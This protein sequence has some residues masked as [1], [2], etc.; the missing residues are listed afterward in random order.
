MKSIVRLTES[1]LVRIIK[2]IIKEGESE[3]IYDKLSTKLKNAGF[4]PQSDMNWKTSPIKG[5]NVTVQFPN[6]LDI[7]AIVEVGGKGYAHDGGTLYDQKI[8]DDAINIYSMIKKGAD[9]R[10]ITQLLNKYGFTGKPSN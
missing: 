6:G 10:Y 9:E 3:D 7:Y 8:V 1:D 2:K 4:K 5:M